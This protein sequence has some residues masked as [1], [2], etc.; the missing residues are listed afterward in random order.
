M[1]GDLAD[2]HVRLVPVRDEDETC[3]QHHE[4]TR[5]QGDLREN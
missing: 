2:V 1:T 3:R 5:D 4:R